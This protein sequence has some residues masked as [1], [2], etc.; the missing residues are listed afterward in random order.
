M[1]L[2]FVLGR[3][4]VFPVG[5]LGVRDGLKTLLD[6]H[7]VDGESMTRGGMREFA[8][9][10]APVRSYATLYLWRVTE[11]IAADVAEVVED[12]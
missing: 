8:E 7:G 4:D 6:P 1:F 12:G 5:D 10:W 11:D 2:L 9:R 3:P